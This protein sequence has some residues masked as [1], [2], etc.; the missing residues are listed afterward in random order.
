MEKPPQCQIYCVISMADG[1]ATDVHRSPYMN[2][3]VW[4]ARTL[5]PARKR[6]IKKRI[7][8]GLDLVS[9]LTGR[10][11]RAEPPVTYDTP[12]PH[13][14]PGERVMVQPREVIQSMLGPFNDYKGLAI[15]PGMW[16]YCGTEQRVLKPVMRYVDERELRMRKAS[17]IVLLEGVMCQG[18]DIYP[19]DRSCFYFWRE[20][21]LKKLD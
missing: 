5:G 6:A 2:F 16:Q 20:E 10:P 18:T 13:F 4:L 1:L 15:M 3:R 12:G 11:K 14:V 19:C 17:G 8:A 9:R 7:A 21:W